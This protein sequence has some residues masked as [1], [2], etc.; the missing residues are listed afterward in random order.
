MYFRDCK[1]IW[2]PDNV[3]NKHKLQASWKY[4]AYAELNCEM[5]DLY[6][7]F[8]EKRFGFK[9][10][11]PLRGSHLTFI[12]DRFDDPEEFHKRCLDLNIDKIDLEIDREIRFNGEHFWF[13]SKSEQAL[14]IREKLGIGKPH[15]GLHVT[16][17]RP[18]VREGQEEAVKMI[19]QYLINY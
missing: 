1:I 9:I 4:A 17:G 8:L 12:N 14:E 19:E 15:F 13:R 18:V 6:R 7:W 11:P 5:G 16:I 2:N 3:T 10:V